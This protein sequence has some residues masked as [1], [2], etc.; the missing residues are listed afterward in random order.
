MDIKRAIGRALSQKSVVTE[1]S[2]LLSD[3]GVSN[4]VAADGGGLL[5][6]RAELPDG[7]VREFVGKCKTPR[8]I[9]RGNRLLS[10]GDALLSLMLALEHKVLGYNGSS[11]REAVL[12]RGIREDLAKYLPAFIGSYTQPLTRT[13]FVALERFP[14]TPP[15]ASQ[16]YRLIDIITEFHAAYY[17]D[18]DAARLLHLNRYSSRDYKA[19]RRRLM[20][21]HHRLDAEN[22]PVFGADKLAVTE[23]FLQRIHTEHSAVSFHRTLTHNDLS[24]RNISADG[25]DII[26]Y[27]WELAAYQNPEHDI[28][29]LL[30]SMLHQLTDSEV[31]EALAYQRRLLAEKT[32]R[33]LTDAQYS[34]ILRFNTLE[35]CVNKLTILRLAGKQLGLD[36]TVQLAVNAARMMDILKIT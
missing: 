12:Y 19:M 36:N 5:N 21:M 29:E 31:L 26:I 10:S 7:S 18:E 13:C 32:G 11:V 22:I 17:L 34:A 2:P 30:I 23:D 6:C 35:H 15:D 8:I 20:R 28:I 14:Q 33:P 16:L 4:R 9:L 1:C 27:D 3:S 25:D 24:T